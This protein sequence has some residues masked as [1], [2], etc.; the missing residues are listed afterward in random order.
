MKMSKFAGAFF[1]AAALLSPSASIAQAVCK[2]K[3]AGYYKLFL[4]APA[5]TIKL[6]GIEAPLTAG[7]GDRARG[8]QAV[9]AVEKGNCLAC[10]QIPQLSGEPDHGNL[11]PSLDGIGLRYTEAQLRQLI[12]NPRAFYP[13]TIMP[14]YHK[15]DGLTRVATNYEGKTIL[16]DQD[17]EDVVAFLKTL[18]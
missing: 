7:I 15:V 3:E 1:I 16:R 4:A 2:K 17:V 9:A 13:D 8:L 5:T 12:V 14:A 18:R 11:G 10:H 6:A